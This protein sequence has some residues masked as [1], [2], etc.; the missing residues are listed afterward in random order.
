VNATG[1]VFEINAVLKELKEANNMAAVTPFIFFSP[2]VPAAAATVS[3][4]L[5]F[6]GGRLSP[7]AASRVSSTQF[8]VL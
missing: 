3:A 6:L 4:A 7:Q 5:C 2:V 8:T 1:V